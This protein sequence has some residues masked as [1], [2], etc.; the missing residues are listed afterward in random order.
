M[1][2]SRCRESVLRGL[3]WL[4][5]SRSISGDSEVTCEWRSN[6]GR[7]RLWVDLWLSEYSKDTLGFNSYLVIDQTPLLQ[8]SMD[9][10]DCADIASEIPP[11]CSYC[12]VFDGIQAIRVDHEVA[13]VL[14]HRRC[15]ASVSTVKELRQRFLL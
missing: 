12:K 1:R 7:A 4:Q 2:F 3:K 14:V 9:S 15:L 8:E 10:H 13:V 11:T 5:P 6:V